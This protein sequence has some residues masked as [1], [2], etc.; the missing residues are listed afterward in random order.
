MQHNP[1]PMVHQKKL[2][3]LLIKGKTLPVML[4]SPFEGSTAARYGTW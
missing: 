3:I 2:S 1:S 4:E